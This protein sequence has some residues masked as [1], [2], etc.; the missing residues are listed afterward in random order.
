MHGYLLWWL[1]HTHTNQELNSLAELCLGTW[2]A[3]L[4]NQHCSCMLKAAAHAWSWKLWAV[5]LKPHSVIST[6]ARTINLRVI[7]WLLLVKDVVL[8]IWILFLEQQPQGLNIL[9]IYRDIEWGY[10]QLL[11]P[12]MLNLDIQFWLDG[13]LQVTKQ[14]RKHRHYKHVLKF[15]MELLILTTVL[16]LFRFCPAPT[17]LIVSGKIN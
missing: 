10:H 5:V 9:L 12:D 3:K 6:V 4:L 14:Q 15:S 8:H 11:W 16:S 2:L 17:Q 7:S 1:K 13:S